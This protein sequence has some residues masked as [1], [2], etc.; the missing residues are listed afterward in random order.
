[1]IDIDGN[2]TD[3]M[4]PVSKINAAVRALG[5]TLMKLETRAMYFTGQSFGAAYN[6]CPRDSLSVPRTGISDWRSATWRRRTDRAY[7]MLVNRDYKNATEV[8]FTVDA[9]IKTLYRVSPETGKLEAL[10]AKDGKYTVDWM[11]A[12]VPCS[13]ATRISASR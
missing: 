1:M 9:G 7:S 11:R 10:T 5:P 4:E 8:T 12:R 2:P 3:L 13:P 6:S